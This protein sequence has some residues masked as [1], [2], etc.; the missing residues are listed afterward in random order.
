MTDLPFRGRLPDDRLYDPASDMWVLAAADGTVTVGASAYGLWRAGRIIGFTAKP[1]GAVVERGRSL[2]TV[3]SAKTVIAVHAPVSF[4]L[5][6]GN[7]A[8]EDMA[9]I[10]NEDP[11]AAGW[12]ARGRPLHWP[13]EL[14]LLLD[15]RAYRA[16]ILASDP[17]AEFA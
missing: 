5:E 6:T 3:E 12:M 17:T 16:H 4:V 13:Q 11:Y 1:R 10:V 15:G 9:I 8:L 2:G 7:E 14:A